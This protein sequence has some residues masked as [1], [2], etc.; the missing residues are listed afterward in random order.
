MKKR[1][2]NIIALIFLLSPMS[3]MAA[4]SPVYTFL[5]TKV[6]T[7]ESPDEVKESPQ[8]RRVPSAL[9]ECVVTSECISIGTDMT[10]CLSFEIWDA[11]GECCIA[12]YSDVDTF[13][14][15][16]FS[17]D[18]EFQVRFVFADFMLVGYV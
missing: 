11:D 10:E 17:M 12:T 9:I 3:S 5:L 14:E 8:R 2:Q 7:S 16:V 6:A 13:I 15:G 4:S 1:L 18:G